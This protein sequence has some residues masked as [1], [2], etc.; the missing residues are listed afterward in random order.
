MNS[1]KR[2]SKHHCF[3]RFMVYVF[4]IIAIRTVVYNTPSYKNFTI[5]GDKQSI[6]K[7][8]RTAVIIVMA[9]AAFFMVVLCGANTSLM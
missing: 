9:H 8:I 4:L 5:Q 7:A 3:H 1:N 6:F 2:E